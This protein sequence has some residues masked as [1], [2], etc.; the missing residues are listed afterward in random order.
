MGLMTK[1]GVFASFLYIFR[2]SDTFTFIKLSYKGLLSTSKSV[3]HLT[4]DYESD[5]I[6]HDQEFSAGLNLQSSLN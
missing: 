6:Q 1:A 3:T 2:I 5:Q 4:T